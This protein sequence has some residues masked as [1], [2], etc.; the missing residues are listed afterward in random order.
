[1]KIVE[2]L[3][4]LYVEIETDLSVRQFNASTHGYVRKDLELQRKR[5]LNDEAYFLYLFSRLED[6]IREQSSQLITDKQTNLRNWRKRAV[7]DILPKDK[8]S[9]RFYFM[10]RVAILTEKGGRH[11]N[12]VKTYYEERNNIAHGGTFSTSINMFDV[13]LKMKEL[14]KVLSNMYK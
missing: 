1:M 6:H 10:N 11:Y 2:E 4:V 3:S 9:D 7:W 5:Q 13:F 14:F 12:Q 8:D